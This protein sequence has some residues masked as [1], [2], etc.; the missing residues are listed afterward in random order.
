M[1]T[2]QPVDFDP[3]QFASSTDPEYGTSHISVVCSQGNAASLTTTIESAF[4]SFHM[5]DGF[6]LN[7][8]LTDFAAD[9]VGPAGVPVPN[10]VAPAKRPPS[11]LAPPLI[12]DV[13]APRSRR[14]PYPVPRPPGAPPTIHFAAKTN[15]GL[16]A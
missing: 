3:V 5:V 9:P 14:P 11:T 16:L 4:G 7:N 2:A 6:L 1:C 15:V 8:Q 12:F 10:S 13:G